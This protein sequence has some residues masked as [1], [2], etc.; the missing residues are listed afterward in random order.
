[1]ILRPHLKSKDLRPKVKT[2]KIWKLQYPATLLW[3]RLFPHRCASTFKSKAKNRAKTL[4]SKS[5]TQRF[6]SF[7]TLQPYFGVAYSAP[8]RKYFLKQG[9]NQSKDLR[10]KI[11]G[12]RIWKLQYHATLLW[13]CLLLHR[14]AS[15]F[16]SKVKT[17][18][19]L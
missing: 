16:K 18:Q 5:K 9:Q 11:K 6:K 10:P 15:T 17:R 1:V 13:R 12:P 19:R 14:C 3:R 2:S 4:G 8:L 7:N